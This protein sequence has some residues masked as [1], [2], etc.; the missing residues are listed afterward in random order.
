MEIF[1]RNLATDVEEQ[2]LRAV[3]EPFG[4]VESVT[5]V[6]D[7]SSGRRMGFG[8]VNMPV[9]DEAISAIN[10]LDGVEVKGR[11][12]EFHASR[13]RFERRRRGNR[14][15]QPRPDVDRREGERR[16]SGL[17]PHP[18]ENPPADEPES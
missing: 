14:R 2:D 3:F 13:T 16:R 7:S 5:F 18:S 1:I 15:A 17:A 12:L 8:F 6:T 10:A 9:G 11:P 4:T